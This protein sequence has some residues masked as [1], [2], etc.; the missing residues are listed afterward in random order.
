MPFPTSSD[1]IAP[2]LPREIDVMIPFPFEG[3]SCSEGAGSILR[4]AN[5]PPPVG[6][7]CAP[8]ELQLKIAPARSKYVTMQVTLRPV[9]RRKL[10]SAKVI[11]SA[12]L[13]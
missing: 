4:S 10:P 7:D 8:T 13:S 5:S 9:L 6:P 12:D 2:V 3:G 1:R 11:F